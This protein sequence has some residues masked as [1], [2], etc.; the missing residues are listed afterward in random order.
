MEK[1]FL[2]KLLTSIELN[3][4]ICVEIKTKNTNMKKKLFEKLTNIFMI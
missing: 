3:N 1:Y 4:L 2:S